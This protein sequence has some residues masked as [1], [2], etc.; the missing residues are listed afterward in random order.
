[1][2]KKVVEE[3]LTEE[4]KLMKKLHDSLAGRN[5]GGLRLDD[6]YWGVRKDVFIQL[7]NLKNK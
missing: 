6:P 1:M 3:K 2:E 7:A 4:Q 5:E